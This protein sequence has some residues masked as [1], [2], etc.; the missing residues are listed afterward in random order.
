MTRPWTSGPACPK[1]GLSGTGSTLLD[2]A[3]VAPPACICTA[4][5]HAWAGTPEERERAEASD[6]AW[7]AECERAECC[8]RE[9]AQ[10]ERDVA[11][12]RSLYEAAGRP[13][14]EWLR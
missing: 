3:P 5:G 4:C 10:R 2:G 1:C 8:E 7:A 12:A 9:K 13:L 6:R 14:P 11:Q